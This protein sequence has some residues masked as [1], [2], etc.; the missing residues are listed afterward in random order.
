MDHNALAKDSSSAAV[1]QESPGEPA[2]TFFSFPRLPTEVQL[3]IW[4][5]AVLSLPVV[6]KALFHFRIVGDKSYS[7]TRADPGLVA[8]FDPSET[9]VRSVHDHVALLRACHLSRLVFLKMKPTML[10][11]KTSKKSDGQISERIIQDSLVPFNPAEVTEF[12]IMGLVESVNEVMRGDS[13]VVLP[14]HYTKSHL[15]A[16]LRG[17][18]F[19]PTIRHVVFMSRA[20]SMHTYGYFDDSELEYYEIGL[21]YDESNP[22]FKQFVRNFPNARCVITSMASGTFGLGV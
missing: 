3:K 6:D 15:V 14:R 12:H 17:L 13:S 19:A 5:E 10:P 9:F 22:Y 11:I 16:H 1:G 21:R 8:C 20:F 18:D 4:E 7:R 2:T